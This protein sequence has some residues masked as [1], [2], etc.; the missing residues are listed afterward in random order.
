MGAAQ[1]P[2]DT[3]LSNL[4]S[5]YSLASLSIRPG[6]RVL[7]VGCGDGSVAR[8]LADRGCQV[9]GVESEEG[10]AQ[11][12]RH[13][14]ERVIVGDIE[15][16][17]TQRLLMGESFDAIVLLDVLGHLR[18]PL[19]VLVMARQ[20]L[21]PAGRLVA[22]F[23]NVAHGAVRL[24]LLRGDFAYSD[25]GL[26]NRTRVRFFDR[27]SA[28]ALLLEA[29]LRIDERLRVT[30]ALED[31]EIPT[32]TS[33]WPAD[34]VESLRRDRDATTYEFVFVA[35]STAF[36][37]QSAD[38]SLAE[39]LQTR[40]HELQTTC[41]GLEEQSLSALTEVRR[42]ERRSGAS[43]RQI[44]RTTDRA[45]SLEEELTRRMEEL[46][47]RHRETA[48]LRSDVAVRE[49]FIAQLKAQA[50][51]DRS[52]L[53]AVR[54]ELHH[55]HEERAGLAE[56]RASLAARIVEEQAAGAELTAQLAGERD[57]ASQQGAETHAALLVATAELER[58][59]ADS[60]SRE[61]TGSR[62]ARPVA[63]RNRRPPARDRRTR[64]GPAGGLRSMRPA[65][66]DDGRPAARNRRTRSD[67][68][69]RL[70]S[71]CPV[72]GGYCRPRARQRRAVGLACVCQLGRFPAREPGQRRPEAAPAHLSHA[73]VGNQ[74]HGISVRGSLTRLAT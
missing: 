61:A 73:P 24:H 69:A 32:D 44:V 42:K 1:H 72:T 4:N 11:S 13:H 52:T 39:Q 15:D 59:E 68:A 35:S 43:K 48:Q 31:T 27:R 19:P 10:V 28:E 12:A 56:E 14:C 64:S 36:R 71:A 70:R 57:R 34:I 50:A 60:E 9:V 74:E 6:S 67:P 7:D 41:H 8:I 54:S 21:E 23:G 45:G 17:E 63:L 38:L 40:V 46:H 16:T 29:G 65:G 5:A 49:A 33:S 20:L 30:R 51:D 22:S 47:V 55:L 25:T 2:R 3:E 58:L 18:N 66:G 62:S 53:S 26:L 37:G